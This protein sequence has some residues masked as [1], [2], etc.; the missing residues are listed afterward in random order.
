MILIDANLGLIV[1]DFWR[2]WS[3]EEESNWEGI[4]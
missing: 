3:Q 4:C 1:L 2:D